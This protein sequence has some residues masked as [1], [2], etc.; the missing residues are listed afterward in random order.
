ML[1]S[2][3]TKGFGNYKQANLNLKPKK[4]IKS[5]VKDLAPA[6][7]VAG[8]TAGAINMAVDSDNSKRE[9]EKKECQ[10]RGDSYKWDKKKHKCILKPYKKT[11]K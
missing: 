2:E 11:R 8:I 5:R 7:L 4:S 3:V 10:A 9:E 1:V 6:A